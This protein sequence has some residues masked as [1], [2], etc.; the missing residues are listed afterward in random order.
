MSLAE[1]KASAPRQ[2][3]AAIAKLAATGTT[4]H[5]AELLS[6]AVRFYDGR[7][8]RERAESNTRYASNWNIYFKI[9]RKKRGM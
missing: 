3:A 9:V 1:L 4:E 6:E 2:R 8:E 5:S 7:D